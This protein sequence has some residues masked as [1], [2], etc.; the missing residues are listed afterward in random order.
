MRRFQCALLAT[1]ALIGFASIASA[2]DLPMKAPVYKAPLATV[3]SWTGCYLGGNVGY[4]WA[5]TKW[6]DP[7]FAGGPLTG[8]LASHTAEGVVGGGQIGCDYQIG[9]WVFGIQGMFDAS[10]MKGQSLNT[11]SLSEGFNITDA[12]K[13]PWTATLTGRI[14]YTLQPITLLYIKGGFAWVRAEYTECCEQVFDTTDDGFA[15]VTRTGWTVGVGLEHMFQPHWSAFLEYD[16]IGLGT[17]AITFTPTN[18]TRSPFVYS[19]HQDVQMVLAGVNY[20]F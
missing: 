17:D 12:T 13:L 16:F 14:G 10:G 15:K 11:F 2:A 6:S 8:E 5:P 19:I 9:R 1:V 20:R 3:A 4:G 7:V 18:P